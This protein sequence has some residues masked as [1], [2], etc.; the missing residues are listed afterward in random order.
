M[1][2]TA[3]RAAEKLKSRGIRPS[4]QRVAIYDFLLNNPVHPTAE[5]IFSALADALPTL[6]LTTVYNTLRQ[7]C[8]HQ[9]ARRVIIEEGEA[10][11]DANTSPHIHFKCT[12]CG[13]IFDIPRPAKVPFGALPRGFERRE[14]QTNIWGLCADCASS[15][16]EG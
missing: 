5:D 2:T 15:R 8:E 14:V 7:L 13:R 12:E 10:R 1:D 11:Y 6:S 9:L 16:A 3:P 4:V